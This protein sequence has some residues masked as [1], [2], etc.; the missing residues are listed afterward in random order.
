MTFIISIIFGMLL[1]GLADVIFISVVLG[2]VWIISK[3]LKLKQ[4]PQKANFLLARQGLPIILMITGA[5]IFALLSIYY[6]SRWIFTRQNPNYESLFTWGVVLLFSLPG[7]I[8]I[9]QTQKMIKN[10]MFK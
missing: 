8:K 1:L 2:G 5:Y 4:Y 6:L 10:G 3:R 7:L 9:P